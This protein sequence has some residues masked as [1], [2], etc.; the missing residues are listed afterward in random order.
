MRAIF[1]SLRDC[2]ALSHL[3][4]LRSCLGWLMGA[5]PHPGLAPPPTP[6]P[7][8]P[9]R[10]LRSLRRGLPDNLPSLL[11]LLGSRAGCQEGRMRGSGGDV[12]PPPSALWGRRRWG[13]RLSQE[14]G[15]SGHRRDARTSHPASPPSS[16]SQAPREPAEPRPRRSRLG[17]CEG[18]CRD[19][20]AGAG[21]ESTGEAAAGGEGRAARR[22]CGGSGV[23]RRFRLA[24]FAP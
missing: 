21:G 9:E 5:S 19:T 14:S 17:S 15:V 22:T 8:F 24:M 6:G 11:L 7:P 10:P 2:L 3:L 12:L 18:L 4:F 23:R 1:A 20:P 13:R 16:S